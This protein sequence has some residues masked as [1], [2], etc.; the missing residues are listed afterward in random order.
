MKKNG[1]NA[2][3]MYDTVKDMTADFVPNAPY[4]L[5]SNL[6]PQKGLSN[7][8][9]GG[10]HSIVLHPDE[11][12]NLAQ[13]I[14]DA[15]LG[16]VV[17]LDHPPFCVTVSVDASVLSAT[18]MQHHDA[19]KV[20]VPLMQVHRKIN[21]H[22]YTAVRTRG[23][24]S[25]Y[26]QAH[27]FRL[28]FGST[29]HGV[30]CRSMDKIILVVDDSSL[31]ALTYNAFYVG[32]SRVRT[33]AGLRVIRLRNREEPT[34]DWLAQLKSLI[35]KVMVVQYMLKVGCEEAHTL[36]NN[37]YRK[38]GIDY[39]KRGQDKT[40]HGK[41]SKKA[42][43]KGTFSCIKQCGRIFATAHHR[44]LHEACCKHH[45]GNTSQEE[46]VL[47]VSTLNNKPHSSGKRPSNAWKT[48]ARKK[49]CTNEHANQRE[50]HNVQEAIIDT[51]LQPTLDE[52]TFMHAATEAR[53][54]L[55]EHGQ[56]R[57]ERKGKQR[58]RANDASPSSPSKRRH[59]SSSSTPSTTCRST[60]PPKA[61][62]SS[63]SF[64]STTSPLASTPVA[65]SSSSSSSSRNVPLTHWV[66]CHIS[67]VPGS[68][69]VEVG[70]L[71]PKSKDKVTMALT[72][73]GAIGA[74]DVRKHYLKLSVQLHPDK[75]QDSWATDRFQL[76]LR[77]YNL[78]KDKYKLH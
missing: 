31:P 28:T 74:Q 40:V 26:T 58:V 10:L 38:F 13:E 2:D 37:M 20:I 54:L 29:Y 53:T 36:L 67:A 72:L 63:P 32:I 12:Q 56:Q 60:S 69:L 11:V 24:G 71:L 70:P 59:H 45:P 66:P 39:D 6:R 5:T 75:S 42:P 73:L 61:S 1:N 23:G 48:A 46:D 65:S 9:Q 17:M 76:L 14:H 18:G 57:L 47:D 50:V 62:S 21:I 30:Q 8:T 15:R 7:G 4:C 27:P 19:S 22:R 51:V 68:K 55:D 64:S 49:Q 35:P 3:F 41:P 34:E 77:A 52:D 25:L 33:A 44:R 78:L 16:H 43:K